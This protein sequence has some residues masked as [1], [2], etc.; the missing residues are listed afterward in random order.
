[1]RTIIGLL[2][3]AILFIAFLTVLEDAYSEPGFHR[4]TDTPVQKSE[5]YLEIDYTYEVDELD[6]EGRK[7]GKKIKKNKMKS[8]TRNWVEN[9]RT[10]GGP[11]VAFANFGSGNTPFFLGR[12]IK[13]LI[14][15][16]HLDVARDYTDVTYLDSGVTPMRVSFWQW[17]AVFQP[18]YI[19][20]DPRYHYSG[21]PTIEI[22]S[23]EF[24]VLTGE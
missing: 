5:T 16:G 7:T 18:D 20:V 15:N 23:G 3:F 13:Q 1:M 11:G 8:V 6:E 2:I 12:D 10:Q 21:T 22:T 19:S 14:K 24:E 17:I 4:I 9:K